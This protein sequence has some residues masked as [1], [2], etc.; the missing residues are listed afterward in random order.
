MTNKPPNHLDLLEY[1]YERRLYEIT[2]ETIEAL[3]PP[4]CQ[5]IQWRFWKTP[6][7]KK[8]ARAW[9]RFNRPSY[10]SVREVCRTLWGTETDKDRQLVFENMSVYPGPQ[11]SYVR[12]EDFELYKDKL[13]TIQPKK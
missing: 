6:F 13:L 7:G 3:V 9:W 8:L 1:D 11:K 5:G 12:R 10:M 2:E 4:W